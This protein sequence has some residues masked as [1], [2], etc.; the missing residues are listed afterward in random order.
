VH[1]FWPDN[2]FGEVMTV[3]LIK[4]YFKA[5]WWFVIFAVPFFTLW[6][7]VMPVYDWLKPWDEAVAALKKEKKGGLRW[8][9]GFESSSESINGEL[10]RYVK[11]RDFVIVPSVF[12]S[13]TVYEFS[14]GISIEKGLK[15]RPYHALGYLAMY[16]GL[17][18]FSWFV[19]WRKIKWL[20]RFPKWP[21]PLEPTTTADT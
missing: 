10:T 4:W 3:K 19:S 9:V 7:P 16:A 21:N 13:P 18:A 8:M 6:I 14:E 5:L 15:V 17:I 12:T 1:A 20:F 2:I 11:Q